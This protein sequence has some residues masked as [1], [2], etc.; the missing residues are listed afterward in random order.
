MKETIVFTRTQQRLLRELKARH[1]DMWRMD[2]NATL[3][4][5]Y[6]EQG[7]LG[8]AKDGKHRFSL[9]PDFAGVDISSTEP[10]PE[11]PSGK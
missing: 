1:D 5:I 8:M 6:D 11:I 10:T 4:V 2:L 7:V 3:E 9:Q